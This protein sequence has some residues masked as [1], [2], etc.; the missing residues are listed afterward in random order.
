[1]GKRKTGKSTEILKLAKNYVKTTGKRVLIINPND[2][3]V[4]ENVQSIDYK[5]LFRW[6]KGIKQMW[7]P[8]TDRM[9][10]TLSTFFS[11]KNPVKGMVVFEDSLNYIPTSVP[12]PIKKFL[13]DCRHMDADL[14]FTFHALK[15]VPPWFWA[16]T[17][18]VMVKRTIEPIEKD[19]NWY[20]KRIPNMEDIKRAHISV[21]SGSNELDRFKC[22]TVSTGL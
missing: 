2:A 6:K 14:V 22:I 17:N 8:D 18:F 4:Y 15:F 5:Q 3:E 19:F 11:R 21:M 13:L 20:D 7:D 1:M 12:K 9:L 16:M 10:T